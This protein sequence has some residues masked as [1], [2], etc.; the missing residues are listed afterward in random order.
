MLPANMFGDDHVELRAAVDALA[1]QAQ[2]RQRRASTR[3][4][5]CF[6]YDTATARVAVVVAVDEPFEA[7]V[8]Q[9]RRIDDEL[10]RHGGVRVDRR[11][12]LATGRLRRR[13]CGRQDQEAR[14]REPKS[15][16]ARHALV[17]PVKESV[18]AL[19][20]RSGRRPRGGCAPFARTAPTRLGGAARA[21]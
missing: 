6:R 2:Q 13:G 18:G 12:R 10:A 19:S 8:D 3:V 15:D 14:E 20:P 5:P 9:R 7:E 11:R 16:A 1:L 4:S 17:P 21:P